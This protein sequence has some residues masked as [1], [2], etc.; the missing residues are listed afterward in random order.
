MVDRRIANIDKDLLSFTDEQQA[1]ME[2]RIPMTKLLFEACLMV[3]IDNSD[4]EMFDAL[5]QRFPEY[6]S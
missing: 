6:K 2:H 3:C 4:Y 5:F 1:A